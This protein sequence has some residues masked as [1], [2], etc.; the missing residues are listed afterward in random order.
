MPSRRPRCLA[1]GRGG[2]AHLSGHRPG[3][4]RGHRAHGLRDRP[5]RA[6]GPG[7]ASTSRR[8]CRTGKAPSPGEGHAADPRLPAP[9]ARAHPGGA[10]AGGRGALLRHARGGRAAP[11][12]RRRR[13]H[14]RQRRRGAAPSSRTPSAS[15]SSRRSW[16]SAPTT[17]REPLALRMLGMHGAAF[18]NYA[19]DD[20]DFLIAVG[21]RFDDRVAGVPEK[22]APQRAAHRAPRRR[23]GRGRT[24]S[25]ACSGAT[26]GCMAP[27]LRALTAHGRAGGFQ[28]DFAPWA[29]ELAELKRRYAMN[30]D[31]DEPADPA[32]LRDRGDQPSRARARRSSAPASASTRCGRRSTVDFVAPRLWLTS[33]S[34]GTMGFGLPA[35]IGAQFAQPAAP[36]DRHRRRLPA[37]A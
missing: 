25:S 35:A 15:R 9:H 3:E 34:M 33:G 7:G 28:R 2:Q 30:Y 31:R 1:H 10:R 12:L 5:H 17:P 20:C 37:S 22:F 27:A 8:T 24:R 14:Q 29:A 4:A 11:D 32:V 13:R 36:G 21:A 6:P 18:A 19:V 16:G 26:S 23:P